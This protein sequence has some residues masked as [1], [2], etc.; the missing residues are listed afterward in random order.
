MKAWI[1]AVVLATTLGSAV[2]AH[3]TPPPP[4][5]PAP[6]GAV[7]YTAEDL[8]TIPAPE[9]ARRMLDEVVERMV[10]YRPKEGRFYARPAAA[11][12]GVC[13]VESMQP[14]LTWPGDRAWVD[15]LRFETRYRFAPGEDGPVT[16]R[17]CEALPTGVI[18][19][20]APSDLTAV[21]ILEA[22]T[23]AQEAAVK[24]GR[25]MWGSCIHQGRACNTRLVLPTLSPTAI[26]LVS[27][28]ECG[29]NHCYSIHIQ[30]P[31]AFW[32]VALKT[33]TP[34]SAAKSF[35]WTPD[36]LVGVEIGP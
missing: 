24:G 14:N 6:E 27:E 8:A 9:L 19:F 10:E 13:K 30:M 7:R 11:F 23:K 20:S 29:P 1:S 28:R 35:S 25:V 26:T 22:W 31:E 33:R 36:D 5:K 17:T 21:R 2:A 18:Y 32:M 12:P 34:A 15:G 3:A 16:I 4:P